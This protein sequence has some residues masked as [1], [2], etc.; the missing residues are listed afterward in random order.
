MNNNT[1]HNNTTIQQHWRFVAHRCRARHYALQAI[2]QWQFSF[3]DAQSI[4]KQFYKEFDFSKAD[5][6]YFHRLFCGTTTQVKVLDEQ[7]LDVE[8]A[9]RTFDHII[10][11]LLRMALYELR[12]CREVDTMIII[13]EAVRLA[14]KFGSSGT[15]RLVRALVDRLAI[16]ARPDE[17]NRS[18]Q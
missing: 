18:I 3:S 4:E 16:K 9:T 10:R 2:Y 12:E 1:A 15:D 17:I 11:A 8:D 5:T 13:D 7:L 6:A 14:K